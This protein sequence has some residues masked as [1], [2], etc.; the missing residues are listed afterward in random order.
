[1]LAFFTSDHHVGS[2]DRNA[3]TTT[4]KAAEDL[5]PDVII[6]G[7]D[8]L[9]C[10]E[11]HKSR[12]DSPSP[13]TELSLVQEIEIGKRLLAGLRA[14][15]PDARIIYLEG[16]HEA[17]LLRGAERAAP[18]LVKFLPTWPELLGL[19]EVGVHWLPYKEPWEL[20]EW[21]FLHGVRYNVHAGRSVMQ[22]YGRSVVQGHSHRLKMYS[23]TF[24][25]G[26]TVYGI[27]AGHCHERKAHYTPRPTPD[28]QQGFVVLRK[29]GGQWVPHLCPIT[30]GSAPSSV[31][32]LPGKAITTD[33]RDR[34][35]LWRPIREKLQ[36]DLLL[37]YEGLIERK[38]KGGH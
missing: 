37:E 12:F 31:A 21:I 17:R 23:Q 1:M 18:R 9:D 7:G 35:K 25:D 32:A 34:D 5:Q 14:R 36:E 26:R 13:V 20:D 6:I 2:E 30:D 27:E 28:W 8:F 3:I 15:C 11:L 4:W 10:A 38:R 33:R 29:A 22:E 16:N 24:G 19:D